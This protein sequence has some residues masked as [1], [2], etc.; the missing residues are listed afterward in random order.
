MSKLNDSTLKILK[1]Y[2]LDTD[3][4]VFGNENK[5]YDV[6]KVMDDMVGNQVSKYVG[7]VYYLS[8]T[9]S[10]TLDIYKATS[11]GKTTNTT[12]SF[13]IK[14]PQSPILFFDPFSLKYEGKVDET[15]SVMPL[16]KM[17]LN[18]NFVAYL[19]CEISTKSTYLSQDIYGN[20]MFKVSVND[21]DT[22]YFA[23]FLKFSNTI[24]SVSG[25][26]FDYTLL[27]EFTTI[28]S[29]LPAPE[30]TRTIITLPE[31]VLQLDI[32]NTIYCS[33]IARS[34]RLYSNDINVDS[35][36]KFKE[37]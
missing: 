3:M 10:S 7:D 13:E 28:T 14:Q 19:V 20:N 34:K 12:L 36:I 21:G 18:K 6:V 4:S 16:A 25:N 15:S 9:K 26:A 29:Y 30:T 17:Y 5:L 32:N 31:P 22:I 11:S 2:R 8:S 24:Y 23:T 37:V 1:K 27:F 33:N 35:D